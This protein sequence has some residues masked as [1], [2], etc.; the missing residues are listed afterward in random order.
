MI[1]VLDTTRTSD[2]L[3]TRGACARPIWLNPDMQ[4]IL[5]LSWYE[6]ILYLPRRRRGG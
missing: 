6:N 3:V 2:Q 5:C 4:N 1:T